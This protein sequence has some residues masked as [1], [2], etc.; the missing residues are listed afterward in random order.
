MTKCVFSYFNFLQIIFFIESFAIKVSCLI[1]YEHIQWNSRI[2]T[3]KSVNVLAL[4]KR[5]IREK[6]EACT[7]FI[8]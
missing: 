2:F 7:Y 8:L 3:L 5:N 1:H 6:R 4:G